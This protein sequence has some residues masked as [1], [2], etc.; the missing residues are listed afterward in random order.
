VPAGGAV[1]STLDA[2][3][4]LGAAGC[5]IGDKTFSS[6]S[7]NGDGTGVLANQVGVTPDATG[8]LG[9]QLNGAWGGPATGIND[10]AI[11]FTVAITPGAAP[12]GTLITDASLQV[13][14]GTGSFLNTEQ[15]FNAV[16]GALLATITTSDNLPHTAA[17]AGVLSV[18]ETEDLRLNPGA[19]VSIVD[20]R[21][22][23]TPGVPMPE[24]AS[25]ALL[26][27][28]LPPLVLSGGAGVSRNI[29]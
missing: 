16:G 25:L 19:Q 4:A 12:A 29:R 7:Y 11:N 26:G 8:N 17:F 22:S 15:L 1:G 21:F 18:N 14:N 5:Q 6:F 9:V 13:L 24:P 3:I 20:K 10:V 27:A 2:Y 28:V 23:Q